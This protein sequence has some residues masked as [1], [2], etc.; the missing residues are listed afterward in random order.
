MVRGAYMNTDYGNTKYPLCN[1]KIETDLNYNL[2]IKLYLDKEFNLQ[3]KNN[4][5][6][7]LILATHNEYSIQYAK[8]LM[9]YN[10][11][12]SFASLLGFSDKIS[13]E[14][15][16]ENYHVF[17]YLPYGNYHD[18]LPYLIRRLY[19]NYSVLIYLMK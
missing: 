6:K 7:T 19:E 5:R 14:L 12:V 13:Q 18:L 3:K 2:G 10:S 4:N 16:N 15:V 11:N 1:N 9:N 17:K 8:K